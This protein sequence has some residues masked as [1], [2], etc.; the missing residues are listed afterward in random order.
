MSPYPSQTNHAKIVE[1]ARQLIEQDG[2]EN[3]SLGKVAAALN[4]KAPSLYRHIK[5]KNALLIAVI[6][7]TYRNLFATY[8]A[9]LAQS[10]DDP[11]EQLLNISRAHRRFAQENPHT[12]VL[13][14]TMTDPKYL[15][16]PD[17]LLQR[18]ISI[19][20]IMVE[21]SGETNALAALRGSLA[22][23]HGYAMLELNGQ[24]R[25][26]GDLDATFDTVLEAYLR[27]W[28][29]APMSKKRQ[30]KQIQKR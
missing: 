15:D 10:G 4:I 29:K 16:D 6:E 18:A 7:Q 1:V 2:V 23:V 20:E 12:Y 24:F 25:R 11:A 19:Q 3:L 8:D 5:N 9:A 27:G 17:L 21:I 22:L 13:A 28:Q 14:Y 30:R 26:G